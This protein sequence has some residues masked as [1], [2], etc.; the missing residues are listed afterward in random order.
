MMSLLIWLFRSR[1]LTMI[2][3]LNSCQLKRWIRHGWVKKPRM[4]LMFLKWL[5]FSGFEVVGV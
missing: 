5:E 1:R 2:R 3:Q 4:L